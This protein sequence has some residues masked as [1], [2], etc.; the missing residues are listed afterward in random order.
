MPGKP[1]KKKEAD[2]IVVNRPINS[3]MLGC[4]ESRW[5]T[6]AKAAPVVSGTTL[7]NLSKPSNPAGRRSK[8]YN[9]ERRLAG[10]ACPGV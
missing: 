3:D 9:R 10:R 6:T 8:G 2:F 1:Q 4:L 7:K 5:E